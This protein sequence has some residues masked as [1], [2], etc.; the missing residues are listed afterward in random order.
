MHIHIN[1]NIHIHTH[2]HTHTH[3]HT[4]SYTYTYINTHTHTHIFLIL[5]LGPKCLGPPLDANTKSSANLNF[6]LPL[7]A[8]IWFLLS[9]LNL[10]HYEE[11]TC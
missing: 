8:G 10:N 3:T 1:I 9:Y 7:A 11:T 2:K 5:A 4:H 6:E